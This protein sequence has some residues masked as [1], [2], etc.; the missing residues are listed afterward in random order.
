MLLPGSY[1]RIMEWQGRGRGGV[2]A[3]F[4]WGNVKEKS[5]F[6]DLEVD[7]RFIN[8]DLRERWLVICQGF[9]RFRYRKMWGFCRTAELLLA[10]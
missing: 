3:Q 1:I 2:R 10:S 9:V 7:G 4:L 5:P 8:M 6:G